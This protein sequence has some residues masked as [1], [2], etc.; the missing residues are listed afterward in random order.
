MIDGVLTFEFQFHKGTIRTENGAIVTYPLN[1]F[2]FHKGTIRTE[3]EDTL[4]NVEYNFNSIKVRLEHEI[5]SNDVS[6]YPISIP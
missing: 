5:F 6:V 1:R 2:Q 4:I 3:W